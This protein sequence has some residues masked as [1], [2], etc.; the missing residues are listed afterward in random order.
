VGWSTLSVDSPE[1]PKGYGKVTIDVGFPDVNWEFMQS[2]YGWPALQYQAWARG[3]LH[4]SGPAPQTAVFF[5]DGLLELWV[6]S[7][8]YFGGDF[9]TYRRSPI[10]LKLNPG[11]H[12]L[13][14]RLIRDVRA[15]GGLGFPRVQVSIEAHISTGQLAVDAESLVVSEV[16]EGKLV[17]PW[18]SI[19]VRNDMPEWVEIL[20]IELCG[21]G[22]VENQLSS[23]YT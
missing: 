19:N 16:V 13:D 23:Q 3:H 20:R 18:T 12:V 21:V 1:A 15:H 9:Y 14:L 7:R 5:T 2:V 6:D 8:Q 17:S 11:P 10:V 4:I 22:D